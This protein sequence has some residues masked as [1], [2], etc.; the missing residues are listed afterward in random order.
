MPAE[1]GLAYARRVEHTGIA[2]VGG[3]VVQ[4]ANR[5]FDRSAPWLAGAVVALLSVVSVDRW[6]QPLVVVIA[7]TSFAGVVLAR[8]WRWPLFA[9]AAA[10][11]VL[12]AIWP[13]AFMAS[14]YAGTHLRR[15]PELLAYVAV[16]V[17]VTLVSYVIPLDLG[18]AERLDGLA[19]RGSMLL[20]MG[21]GLVAGLWVRARREVVT[22]LRE[23]A[24]RLE[25][26]QAARADQARAEE[27]A[28]IAR[29]MHDVVAHR[30][31][32]MVLHAGALEVNAS[33]PRTAETADLIRTTGREAL[34]NLR[35]VLG[36]LRSGAGG[37]VAR[38]PQPVLDDLDRLVAQSRAAGVRVDRRDEGNPRPLPL[39]VERTAYRV[40]QEALTNVHKHAVGATTEVS[41]T[42]LPGEIE[43]AVVNGAPPYPAGDDGEPLPGAGYGLVGVRE[44]VELLGGQ[45][46]AGARGGGGYLVAARLPASEREERT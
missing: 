10:S 27:R 12:L 8:R 20:I 16:A 3:R 42:Y 46:T 39:T 36:V 7:A 11:V 31:S 24:D 40:V 34:A 4:L 13:A 23:R 37:D 22:G 29:E 45:L 5:L 32:L 35:E 38:G 2:P 9:A 6:T 44:R 43:V 26:E 30:V 1:R 15:R 14:Y 21:L 25:R 19:N 28:R 18:G 41:I 33:D 17:P